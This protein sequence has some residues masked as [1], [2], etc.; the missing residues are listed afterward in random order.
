MS[1]K[2]ESILLKVI[3]FDEVAANDYVTIR[4]GGKIDW[5]SNENKE[6]LAKLVAEIDAQAKVGFNFFQPLKQLFL[7]MWE[8]AMI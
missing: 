7:V 6:K 1:R 3:Y 8:V 2:E 4:N 5:S